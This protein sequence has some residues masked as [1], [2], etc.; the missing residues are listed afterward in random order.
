MGQPEGQGRRKWRLQGRAKARRR[1]S[2]EVSGALSKAGSLR[3]Q[4][5]A[6]QGRLTC[7]GSTLPRLGTE[8]QVTVAMESL[9][10]DGAAGLRGRS[11]VVLELEAVRGDGVV[12]VGGLDVLGPRP[13][14]RGGPSERCRQQQREPE[15]GA[16]HGPPVS[17]VPAGRTT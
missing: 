17:S 2:Q 3:A 15:P 14:G 1:A 8:E 4:N 16:C 7:E 6:G 13:Q 11:D 12:P 5:Q 9:V 10:E